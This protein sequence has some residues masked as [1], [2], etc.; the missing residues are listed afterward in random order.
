MD[1]EGEET[2]VLEEQV[3][4]DCYCERDGEVEAECEIVIERV[5]QA[6]SLGV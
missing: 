5:L 3:T 4:A 1:V 2:G 6:D